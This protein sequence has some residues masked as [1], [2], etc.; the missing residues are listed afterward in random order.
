MLIELSLYC[1]HEVIELSVRRASVCQPPVAMAATLVSPAAAVVE[2]LSLPQ[3]MTAPATLSTCEFVYPAPRRL[4][5][6]TSG[7]G[8][9]VNEGVRVR[10]GAGK[11]TGAG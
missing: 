9:G 3:L 2:L 8:E 6:A 11:V 10:E 5:C 1:P 7:K 4:V